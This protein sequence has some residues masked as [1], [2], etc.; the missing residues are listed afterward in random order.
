MA[1]L[2]LELSLKYVVG[3]DRW[4]RAIWGRGK[5]EGKKHRVNGDGVLAMEWEPVQLANDDSGAVQLRW[6]GI[7]RLWGDWTARGFQL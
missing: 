6:S 3:L 5:H 1:G 2:R 4:V 7:A